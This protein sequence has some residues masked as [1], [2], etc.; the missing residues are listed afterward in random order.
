MPQRVTQDLSSSLILRFQRCPIPLESISY[1]QHS[2]TSMRTEWRT[3]ELTGSLVVLD[4]SL[5]STMRDLMELQTFR[6][7]CSM[8][9][10]WGKPFSPV[11]QQMTQFPLLSGIP[12]PGLLP[13]SVCL[14]HLHVPLL[15]S[16]LS[17]QCFLSDILDGEGD[18]KDSL[19]S[20]L[21][22]A[23]PFSNKFKGFFTTENSH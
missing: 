14:S 8:P 21:Y 23:R 4:L 1:S 7:N 13:T 12:S 16:S 11:V 5:L 17:Y 3:I 20:S 9:D 18:H 6:V 2:R 22:F 15:S 10:V 19:L